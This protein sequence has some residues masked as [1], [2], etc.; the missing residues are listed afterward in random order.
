MAD[1]SIESFVSIDGDEG[2]SV[3]SGC[4]EGVDGWYVN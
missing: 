1:S 3:K 4:V 2:V